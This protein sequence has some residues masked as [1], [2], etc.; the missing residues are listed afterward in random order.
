[1]RAGAVAAALAAA[2]LA[3]APALPAKDLG[4]KKGGAGLAAPP[5]PAAGEVSWP[6]IA[7]G[8]VLDYDLR[9]SN[10]YVRPGGTSSVEVV[11]RLRVAQGAAGNE[12]HWTRHEVE[13][14]VR[15]DRRDAARAV[16][17]ALAA[18]IAS[19][20][21]RVRLAGD[22][23]AE[24]V[25]DV[26][27]MLPALRAAMER[28]IAETPGHR[29][30]DPAVAALLD[31]VSRAEVYG[32]HLLKLPAMLNF[33]SGGGVV[34]GERF[35]YDD[36]APNPVTG[37]PF[38]MRGEFVLEAAPPGG[39]HTLRWEVFIDPVKGAP[40]LW[41]TVERLF[42]EDIPA[43]VRSQLPEQIHMG[44]VTR[45]RIDPATGVVTWMHAV[46]TRRILRNEDVVE[47][48]LALRRAP[49]P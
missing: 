16:Q 34:P 6:R 17:Q 19:Q 12:Q 24:A 44:T 48:T 32:M 1:M 18:A 35:G 43:Q 39:E 2:A 11:Q 45:F 14:D 49:S 29:P 13:V 4:N 41:R 7:P 5:A 38:P 8:T 30:G 42:G 46:E 3:F 33:P 22:G 47:T 40:I 25:L 10:R 20:A 9:Q 28:A 37:E 23:T 27:A 15:G 31:G 26:E 21:F 36:E